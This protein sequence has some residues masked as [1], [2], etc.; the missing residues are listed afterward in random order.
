MGKWKM[1]RLGDLCVRITDGSHNP[2]KGID[3][4]DF[5]MLSSKNIFDDEITLIDP[6]YL[7]EEDF[8]SENKRTNVQVGDILVTIVGTIGRSA[9][10]DS[11]NNQFTFQ[12]SVALLKPNTAVF[13]SR[14]GMY[15]IISKRN[16]LEAEARGI[17]QKGIYLGQIKEILIPLPP[18]DEQKRI[19]KNLDLASEIVKGYKEQLAELDK[20]VQSVFYE[21]FGDPVTNEKGWNISVLS[22]HLDV[23]GGYAFKSESFSEDGIPILKIGN[24]NSGQF[25]ST[26][27]VFWKKDDKLK[28]YMVYPG[29]LV[30]SLTGTVGKEDYGN[31]CVIGHEY[32][33]YYL[34]QRN[35]R[36]KLKGQLNTY[37][38]SFL[39]KAPQIKGKL[40]GISRGV[41]Q[42][43][44]S[45]SDILHLAVPVPPPSLQT[46]FA[47]I[48]TEI[49]AQKEH[50]KQALTEAE[51]LFNSLMQ[52]YFE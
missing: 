14:Y 3:Y 1:V 22:N 45:N 44:I 37:Y 19:A 17:A 25:R 40:T 21:M 52:E 13:H 4:S 12:R 36:L 9:V 34:N 39:L 32:N 26:N 24:I 5:L 15:S 42:A 48:V 11:I 23:I 8:N 28:K 6:R 30:I 49:E 46:R 33:C 51:I 47:E 2:P 29:D 18:L 35:A 43:N 27:L 41:R 7:S 50:V 20:L 10:V 31:I 38:L 16:I